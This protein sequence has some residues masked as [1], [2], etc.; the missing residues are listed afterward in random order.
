[1][2]FATVIPD[3]QDQKGI[4][5]NFVDQLYFILVAELDH[6]IIL[7]NTILEAICT[8]NYE[9]LERSNFDFY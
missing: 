1:M 7:K 6:Q 2:D 3:T 5:L 4:G 8:I 9:N